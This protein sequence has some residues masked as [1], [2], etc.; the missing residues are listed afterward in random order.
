MVN[1]PRPKARWGFR[2][3]GFQDQVLFTREKVE[4]LAAICGRS[5][6]A[7]VAELRA[8]LN[9]ETSALQFVRYSHETEVSVPNQRA[10][11]R[12]LANLA[13]RL[14]GHIDDADLTT[15]RTVYSTYR[16]IRLED[17]E[18][19]EMDSHKLFSRDVGHLRRLCGAFEHALARTK[20]TG[21]RPHPGHLAT[22]CRVLA[23]VYERFSDKAFTF[24]RPVGPKGAA[25]FVTEGTR[26]VAAAALVIWP[27][28]TTGNL[29]TVMRRIKSTQRKHL[30][31]PARKKG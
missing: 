18:D 19:V 11:L 2:P 30:R 21:G 16:N 28:A 7:A 23:K 8:L 24:D 12:V 13:H 5:D 31:K 6:D 29:A 15:R 17:E 14:I 9:E 4:E 3:P 27:D 22:T 10:A 1:K 26:F 25:G 20:D